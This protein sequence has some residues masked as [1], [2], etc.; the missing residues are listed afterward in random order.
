MR[1]WEP[2][3]FGTL[4][5]VGDLLAYPPRTTLAF[6]ARISDL[7][8]LNNTFVNTSKADSLARLQESDT[9]G[10]CPS[11]VPTCGG[12]RALLVLLKAN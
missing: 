3:G 9:T 12:S 10:S 2:A 5:L 6:R 1:V 8:S 7:S 4:H 11:S